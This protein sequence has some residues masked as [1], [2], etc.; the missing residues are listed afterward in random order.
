MVIANSGGNV[1]KDQNCISNIQY[2]QLRLAKSTNIT[3]YLKLLVTKKTILKLIYSRK[4][5][6]LFY[7]TECNLLHVLTSHLSQSV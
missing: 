6:P 5:I 1:K 7:I 2:C 3:R 4:T